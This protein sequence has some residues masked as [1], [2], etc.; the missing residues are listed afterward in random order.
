MAVP[1]ETLRAQHLPPY[2]ARL[3][4]PKVQK[5]ETP[6]DDR[7]LVDVSAL[8]AAVKNTVEPWYT[9]PTHRNDEHHFYWPVAD[10]PLHNPG[11]TAELK[12]FHELPINKGYVPR[13]FHNWLHSVTI[14]PAQPEGEVMVNRI[15]S[16]EIAS[17]L[18]QR[19]RIATEKKL[20]IP[21]KRLRLFRRDE[22]DEPEVIDHEIMSEILLNYFSEPNCDI[23]KIDNYVPELK[24]AETVAQAPEELGRAIGQLVIRQNL[25][26]V[27]QVIAA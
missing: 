5:I 15:E 11:G 18:F 4:N 25:L 17:S 27:P 6:L 2:E 20:H 26:L 13:V 16:W 9:W 1:A 21:H 23:A 7:G 8:I 19:A 14:P 22:N 24:L 10:Y 12:K 3:I